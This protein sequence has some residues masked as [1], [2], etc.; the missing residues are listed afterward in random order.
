MNGNDQRAGIGQIAAQ[1]AGPMITVSQIGVMALA[2]RLIAEQMDD[3]NEDFMAGRAHGIGSLHAEILGLAKQST[4]R[5][6]QDTPKTAGAPKTCRSSEDLQAICD[7]YESGVGHG[8][9]RDGHMDG[10][11]YANPDLADAYEIGY[12]EGARRAEN[13]APDRPQSEAS[14]ALPSG[15]TQEVG[16]ELAEK[17]LST[18][19]WLYRRLPRGYGR[20]PTVEGPILALAKHTG[21][22]VTDC[23][24]ERGPDQQA[25]NENN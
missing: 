21:I 8:L 23:L 11:V 20:P 15:Q 17:A 3:C 13:L 22:D 7:A 25:P 1:A 10:D 5:Q 14:D 12:A 2:R 18:L 6:A 4:T 24:A 19:L 9:E 16:A